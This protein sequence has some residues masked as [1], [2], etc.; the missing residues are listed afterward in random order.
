MLVPRVSTSPQ[1]TSL[2]DARATTCNLTQPFSYFVEFTVK[3]LATL[4]SAAFPCAFPTPKI[5]RAA[6]VYRFRGRQL[7]L[8]TLFRREE[9]GVKST[10]SNLLHASCSNIA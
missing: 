8:G 4:F 9:D 1:N 6:R 7:V 5:E 2:T 10:W 3:H